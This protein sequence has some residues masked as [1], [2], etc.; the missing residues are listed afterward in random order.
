M[1]GKMLWRL[2]WL[3][4]FVSA[5]LIPH[6]RA[7]DANPMIG[8]GPHRETTGRPWLIRETGK[9]NESPDSNW[10]VNS[11]AQISRNG[12]TLSTIQG[13]LPDT[14]HFRMLY[15]I[16]NPVDTDNG[17]RPQNILRLVTRAKYSNV[18][19]QVFFNISHI[20]ASDSPNRNQ[21]NGVLFFHRYQ[22]GDNL[23]YAGIRVDGTAV[24]K[25]KFKGK[26][27][28]LKSVTVYPGAYQR[29]RL[30]NLLPVNRWIGMKT[31][32]EDTTGH[33]VAVSLYINDNQLGLGWTRVLHA[34]DSCIA[35]ECITK[36]GY[37][38][39]RS[40][41]MDVRFESYQV[42]EIHKPAY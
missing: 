35:E 29:D 5:L 15:A 34:M 23:Y 7:A 3:L 33:G 18:V 2:A 13:K 9:M 28:T 1:D 30:P 26:Y 11:G 24:L 8:S 31:E 20:N 36:A 25:K 16:S 21:S 17:Y 41:F 40:D 4:E 39:I 6:A 10:W 27:R 12:D 42:S 37:A 22:D 19:Q 14:D 38:G 32:I